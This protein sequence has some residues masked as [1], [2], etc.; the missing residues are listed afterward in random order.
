MADV[1][2]VF[3]RIKW[4]GQPTRGMGEAEAMRMRDEPGLGRGGEGIV[5]PRPY[6][7]VSDEA[8]AISWS[9]MLIPRL[10]GHGLDLPCCFVLGTGVR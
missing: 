1:A 6:R 4:M 5:C 7:G 8:E 3:R 9:F 10:Q 2:G